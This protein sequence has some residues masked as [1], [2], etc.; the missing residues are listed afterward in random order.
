[1]S[2]AAAIQAAVWTQLSHDGKPYPSTGQEV[3]GND[4]K[5]DGTAIRN[6][7]IGVGNL[8]AVDTPSLTFQWT[9][10]DTDICLSDTVVVLCSYISSATA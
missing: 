8:L 7:L 9:T 4:Y 1:M 6:F 5:Y 10:L 2:K 3:M